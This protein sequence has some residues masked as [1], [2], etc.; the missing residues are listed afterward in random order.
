MT[1]TKTKGGRRRF[2]PLQVDVPAI[3]QGTWMMGDPGNR[4]REVET[5]RTGIDLGLTHIDTA[6]MY[7]DGRAE[8]MI[9]EA[10][11]GRRRDDLFI[12]SKVL[13]DHAS[14]AGTV[15]ACEKSLKRL[16]TNYLD[17]YLLHWRGSYPLEE[18]FAGMEQLISA[19]KIRAMGVSNFD[20]DDMEEAVDLVGDTA[21]ACNQVL[22][23]LGE[24]YVDA[25]LLPFCQQHNVA[26]VGYA[27]FGHGRFPGPTTK[28]GRVLAAIGERHGATPRQVALAFLVRKPPL[29]TIPKASSVAHVKENAGALHLS[30]SV[31]ELAAI[32]EAFPVRVEGGLPVL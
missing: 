7:G 1:T 28:G 22:Y 13:P 16:R 3:G 29:Y 19:G 18:T 23:H 6:E 11:A 17:V 8:E 15:A 31:E 5:L 32:D 25:R 21:L 26:L 4:A 14:R 30:L 2:G 27:P 9:A 12:V 10:I 20:V 24:R